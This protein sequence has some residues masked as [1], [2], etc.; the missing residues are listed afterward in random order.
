MSSVWTYH[1]VCD[2][3]LSLVFMVFSLFVFVLYFYVLRILGICWE[4]GK[5]MELRES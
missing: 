3:V 2:V 4:K 5:L 1:F